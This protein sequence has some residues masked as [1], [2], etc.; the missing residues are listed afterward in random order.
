[1]DGS[2]ASS[3]QG[4]YDL[5]VPILDGRWFTRTIA[6][7]IVNIQGLQICPYFV[8]FHKFSNCLHAK[9]VSE[10]IEGFNNG[11]LRWALEDINNE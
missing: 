11:L 1:M 9:F 7:K 5:L 4:T 10:R 6:L 3:C 2:C 8:S